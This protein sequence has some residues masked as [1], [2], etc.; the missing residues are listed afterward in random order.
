MPSLVDL[1]AKKFGRWTVLARDGSNKHKQPTWACICECGTRKTITGGQL[2]NGASRS[3][4]CFNK[5]V[6]RAV[7]IERNKTHGL[8]RTPEHNTWVNMRQRCLNPKVKGYAKYGAKGIT[9]D[10]RWDSFENFIADMGKKPTP[11]HSLDRINPLKG[12]GPD[13]CRWAT[14]K[15]QQN[16]R[17]NNLAITYNGETLT[18]PDWSKRFGI[19]IETMRQRLKRGLPLDRVFSKGNQRWAK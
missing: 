16:N 7:C 8:A 10:P 14:M 13:N 5:D 15:Q 11:L 9:V 12:Y 18:M 1:T 4:G 3:C 19:P 17:T 2:T 6:H